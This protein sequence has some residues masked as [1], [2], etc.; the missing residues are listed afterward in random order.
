MS[1][2][3]SGEGT[4]KFVAAGACGTGPSLL[5]VL[6]H[7]AG[8]EPTFN[9]LHPFAGLCVSKVFE[10]PKT[11]INWGPVFQPKRAKSTFLLPPRTVANGGLAHIQKTFLSL[12]CGY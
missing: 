12:L 10:L 11:L 7:R 2:G 6:G 8:L 5:D 4:L 1:I 3:H 9:N